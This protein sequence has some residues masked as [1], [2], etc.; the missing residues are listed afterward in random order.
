[1]FEVSRASWGIAS[2]LFRVLLLILRPGVYIDHDD[3]LNKVGTM[4]GFQYAHSKD[5]LP[6]ISSSP[7]VSITLSSNITETISSRSK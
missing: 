2:N 6:R 5:F 4:T 7:A 1:M 3:I